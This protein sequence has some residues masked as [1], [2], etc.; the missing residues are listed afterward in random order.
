MQVLEVTLP[1]AARNLALDEALLIQ[2]EKSDAPHEVLR[3]WEPHKPIV[4]VGSSSR[5]AVEV[6]EQR[7][8]QLGIPVYRR[9]SG[10]L[11]IVTGPGCLM[12]SLVLSYEL[13]PGLR[14][15]DYAHQFVLGRIADALRPSVPGVERSGTSDL[16]ID[17]R[18]F[19][20]N[21]VRCKRR[22]LLYHGTLL[23][24]FPLELISACLK[25]PPRQPGYREDRNHN[26]FVTNLSISGEALRATLKR[27]FGA[28]EIR[29][30]WPEEETDRLV[31]EKYSRRE[32]NYRS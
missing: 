22:A 18:K 14:S 5:V 13:R 7:V 17:M 9:P 27:A 1:S 8:K 4:V 30:D 15:L 26:D 24:N 32:W 20:G 28:V 11:S 31:R 19:S 2:A 3:L 25:H 21:S 6:D 10:G 16:T 29:E 12:Y 23:Y